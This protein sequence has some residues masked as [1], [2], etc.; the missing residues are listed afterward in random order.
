MHIVEVVLFEYE[1]KNHACARNK[2]TKME[3]VNEPEG[4]SADMV[5]KHVC[6]K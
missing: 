1:A 3:Y 4:S 2:A 5:V 6:R